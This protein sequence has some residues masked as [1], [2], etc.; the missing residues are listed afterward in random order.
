MSGPEDLCA[1]SGDATLYVRGELNARQ[2][3]SFARH[4]RR[5]E[6]CAEAVDLLQVAAATPLLGTAHMPPEEEDD[7]GR[8]APTPAL[9]VI[10]ANARAAR[11]AAERAAEAG[12]KPPPGR[13]R[14]R[15]IPGGAGATPKQPA[16]ASGRRRMRAPVPKSGL[17][18]FMAVAVLAIATVA[19]TSQAAG[20]RYTRIRAG[21]SSGGAAL[22]LEGNHLELLVENMPKPAS[23]SGY[24]IWVGDRADKK[25]APTTAW[26]H[27]NNLG[28][29]GVNVPGDYHQWD[30]IAVYVEPR[31][32]HYTTRSGAVVVGDLRGL[33]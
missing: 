4:L 15:P 7:P 20:I 3:E 9:T 30:A 6:D 19:F 33:R 18:G 24:Q 13:P 32:G 25:L 12:T 17:I 10:A 16:Q 26:I 21:W 28:Q 1:R 23:G 14:L 8:R 11:L 5:C 31:R 22:K 27:L 29:A 2:Q